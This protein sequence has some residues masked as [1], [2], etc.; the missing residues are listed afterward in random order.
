MG[1]NV[2]N[3]MWNDRI[4]RL[5]K[6]LIIFL[7]ELPNDDK[8]I[9]NHP[10]FVIRAI[11]IPSRFSHI[12]A[13]LSNPPIMARETPCRITPYIIKL[14]NNQFT[15]LPISSPVTVDNKGETVVDMT[16]FATSPSVK[17]I[18][19]YLETPKSKGKSWDMLKP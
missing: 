9:Q 14:P 12:L 17:P 15:P 10:Y 18:P 7:G 4:W 6:D 2:R 3:I 13:S 19:N 8:L 1:I 11:S 5:H 16:M